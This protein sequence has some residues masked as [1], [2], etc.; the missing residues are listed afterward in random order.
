MKSRLGFVSNSSSSSF[1]IYGVYLETERLV[2]KH[3]NITGK[4]DDPV[5]PES[6]K[7]HYPFDDGSAYIGKC[8]S[9]CR[10]DQT[11]GDFKKEVRESLN[12]VALIPFEDTDFSI[13]EEAWR[14]G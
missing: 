9:K 8:L 7:A 10:D 5:I 2:K 14:D 11:M 13:M 1:L 6:F 4:Y 12:K 3:F